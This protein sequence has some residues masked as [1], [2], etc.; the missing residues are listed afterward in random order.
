MPT[1]QYRC[2]HCEALHAVVHGMME[3]FAPV[4]SVCG[5][6]TAKAI[7]QAPTVMSHQP[8]PSKPAAETHHC[9]STCVMHRPPKP[10][11]QPTE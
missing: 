5:G 3:E 10:A 7:T 6:F 4:C 2:Q 11:A 9:G 8:E 1:Y